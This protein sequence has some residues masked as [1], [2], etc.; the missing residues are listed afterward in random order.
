MLLFFIIY[1]ITGILIFLLTIIYYFIYYKK[2][3]PK[4]EEKI[5]TQEETKSNTTDYLNTLYYTDDYSNI[6]IMENNDVML[7][8]HGIYIKHNDEFY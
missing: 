4:K 3:L 5:I 6:Y 7:Y 1:E 2:S 8:N